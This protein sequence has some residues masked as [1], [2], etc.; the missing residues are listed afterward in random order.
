VLCFLSFAPPK[1][2]NK[3]KAGFLP[4]APQA[5][6]SSTL[7][8]NLSLKLCAGFLSC[9]CCYGAAFSDFIFSTTIVPDCLIDGQKNARAWVGLMCASLRLL[10]AVIFM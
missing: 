3:E 6:N 8:R 5:K 7:L 9:A 2:R 4:T 10:C 1:E